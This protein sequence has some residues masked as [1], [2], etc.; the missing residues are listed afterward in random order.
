MFEE[1]VK[2]FD[3]AKAEDLFRS[4]EE[5]VIRRNLD[6]D[7][8]NSEGNIV[9]TFP[10]SEI[11][12]T[13]GINKE[14]NGMDFFGACKFVNKLFNIKSFSVLTHFMKHHFINNLF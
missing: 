4:I 8:L 5:A 6:L 9:I 3:V 13:Y 7:V 14:D 1:I 10:S 2:T 12:R 11:F